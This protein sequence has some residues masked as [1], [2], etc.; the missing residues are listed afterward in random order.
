MRQYKIW[1]DVTTPDYKTYN[2]K[3]FGTNSYTETTVNVG[4]SSQNSFEFLKHETKHTEKDDGTRLFE[5]FVD[6]KLI[7]SAI[8]NPK[9]KNCQVLDNKGV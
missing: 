9:T 5:F 6:N 8:Y 1:N 3:S 4:T 7:K 2:S